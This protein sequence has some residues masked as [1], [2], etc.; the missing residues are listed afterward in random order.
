MAEH[1]IED[2]IASLGIV[3]IT[4]KH[5]KDIDV[6]LIKKLLDDYKA[7]KRKYA[8]AKKELSVVNKIRKSL[9]QMEGK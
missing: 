9:S 5:G 1:S 8:E 7:L 6:I 4:Y 3:S 2:V